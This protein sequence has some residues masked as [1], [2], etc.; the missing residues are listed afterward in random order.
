MSI[1]AQF[2][3]S[4]SVFGGEAGV[5][6]IK[7]ATSHHSYCLPPLELGLKS[8]KVKGYITWMEIFIVQTFFY[9]DCIVRVL[10]HAFVLGIFSFV[11]SPSEIPWSVK[12]LQ[13]NSSP[14]PLDTLV[15]LMVEELEDE[16]R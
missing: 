8:S 11:R 2:N 4:K 14:T 3:Y 7:M 12:E 5:L 10:G 13:T 16:S 6:L 9:I 1:L 15:H